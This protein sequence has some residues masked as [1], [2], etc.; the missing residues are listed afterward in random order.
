MLPFASRALQSTPTVAIILPDESLTGI[1][2]L[3]HIEP[4]A[5]ARSAVKLAGVVNPIG[6]WP[7]ALLIPI[8][9]GQVTHGLQ[10][11]L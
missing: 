3:G 8:P 7:M 10:N 6:A 4:L 11:A 2:A 9:P 1:P 5:E